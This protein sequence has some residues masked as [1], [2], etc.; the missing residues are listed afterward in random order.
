MLY[1]DG[2]HLSDPYQKALLAASGY[3]ANN[4]LLPVATA[5]VPAETNEDW[6]F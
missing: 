2:T 6:C 1:I 4:E 5:I 3:D